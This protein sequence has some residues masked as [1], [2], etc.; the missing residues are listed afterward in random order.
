M[1][2]KTTTLLLRLLLFTALW[3]VVS[4]GLWGEW[5]LLVASIAAAAGVSMALWPAGAWRWRLL[6]F[7]RFVPWFLRA[8]LS[9]GIDVAQRAFRRRVPLAPGVIELP[10]NLRAEPARVFFA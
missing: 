5:P 8:S 3:W 7:L 10:L 6:P 2:S 4:E 1:K 9:G